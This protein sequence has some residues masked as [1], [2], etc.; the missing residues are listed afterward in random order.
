MEGRKWRT[1]PPRGGV[2]ASASTYRW[3]HGANGNP[4]AVAGRRSR[5]P[6]KGEVSCDPRYI[7][8]GGHDRKGN[9]QEAV[10]ALLFP[11]FSCVF[12]WGTTLFLTPQINQFEG[13]LAIACKLKRYVD[14]VR[15]EKSYFETT[16]VAVARRAQVGNVHERKPDITVVGAEG[17]GP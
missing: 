13:I 4:L 3:D 5:F 11:E 14:V 9:A 12:G 2:A 8:S 10:V 16:N 1:A 15:F 7:H 17:S 6:N